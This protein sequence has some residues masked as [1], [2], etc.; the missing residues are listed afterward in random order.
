MMLV[1]YLSRE[2]DFARAQQTR[3]YVIV[4][5]ILMITTVAIRIVM[6]KNADLLQRQWSINRRDRFAIGFA[7]PPDG[8]Q[9]QAPYPT[10]PQHLLR[11]THETPA[12]ELMNEQWKMM[13]H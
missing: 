11:Q 12:I 4:T 10:H 13:R 1:M 7:L 6:T 2:V 9:L 8:A 5:T 3:P